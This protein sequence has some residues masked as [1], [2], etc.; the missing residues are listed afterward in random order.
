MI[1]I[2][3]LFNNIYYNYVLQVGYFN[4]YCFIIVVLFS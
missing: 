3:I 2:V 1:Y 4:T